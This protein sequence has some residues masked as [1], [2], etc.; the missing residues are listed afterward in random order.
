MSRAKTGI[1]R[2]AACAGL[3]CLLAAPVASPYP[4]EYGP[5]EGNSPTILRTYQ[6][7]LIESETETEG[8][9]PGG[10]LTYAR[11]GG[12]PS[13][14]RVRLSRGEGTESAAVFMSVV[15]SAGRV[16]AGPT[17]I[18][19]TAIGIPPAFWGDLN[20]DGREDFVALA[21]TSIGGSA[22][23]CDMGFALSSGKGYRITGVR[24]TRG[25][26]ANDFL[27][28]GEGRVGFV[29]TALIERKRRD[30]RGP[31][32]ATESF[33][34]YSMLEVKGDALVLADADPRLGGFP[35]WVP[36]AA[37]PG[38]AAAPTLAEA[39]RTRLWSEVTARIFRRPEAEGAPEVAS[40]PE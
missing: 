23:A 12:G 10:A 9:E 26:G 6:C 37:K 21:V 40:A 22:C 32:A 39:E 34:V 4:D 38:P 17:R 28:L 30:P 20:G 8:A 5:F 16:L 33:F 27:D 7:T 36:I 25:P 2:A 1:A 31:G 29:H 18:A 35:K 13:S 19:D 24:S 3:A 14:A 15:D 11:A